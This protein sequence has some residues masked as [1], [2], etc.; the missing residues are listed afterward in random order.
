MFI[1][2]IKKYKKILNHVL[3]DEGVFAPID[4]TYNAN[5]DFAIL[6]LSF[7]LF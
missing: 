7:M 4:L 5:N 3:F 1:E 6:N 2:I